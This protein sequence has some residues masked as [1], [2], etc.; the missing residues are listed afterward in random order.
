MSNK[1]HASIETEAGVATY[2]GLGFSSESASSELQQE[3]QKFFRGKLAEY[4]V[5]SPAE[6]DDEQSSKF[7]EEVKAD[8]S[9]RKQ[10]LGLDA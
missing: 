10:R 1:L 3:Y 2:T 4:E 7:F 6:L 9:A 5:S 8:W